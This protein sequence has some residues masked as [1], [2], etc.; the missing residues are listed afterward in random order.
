MEEEYY[1]Y[2]LLDPRWSGVWNYGNYIFEN[3][4]FYV[5]KGKGKRIKSHFWKSSLKVKSLK[6]NVIK[7]ILNDGYDKPISFKIYD[8]LTEEKALE[9]EIKMIKFFGRLDRN[10]GILANHTDG[11]DGHSGCNLPKLKLRKRVYQ[12]S[13]CGDF[14]KEWDSISSIDEILGVN[15]SNVSTAIKRNGTFNNSIWSYEYLGEKIE[16]KIKYQMPLKITEIKQIDKKTGDI[17]KIFDSVSTIE[18]ELGL[19]KSGR[20]LIYRCLNNKIKS[21]YGYKWEK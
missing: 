19:K 17:I 9:I 20:N 15:S 12:Y 13:L 5:G 8:G 21:A 16:S 10:D 1:V 11:G 2:V 14:I 4:P 3:K 6:N 18:N 7:A